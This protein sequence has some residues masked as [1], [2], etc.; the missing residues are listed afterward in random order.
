MCKARQALESSAPIIVYALHGLGFNACLIVTIRMAAMPQ[1]L[2][3][4]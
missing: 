1:H 2:Q 4:Q 3:G